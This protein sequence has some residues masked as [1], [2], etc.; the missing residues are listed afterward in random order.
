MK[1]I[2]QYR[3]LAKE[4]QEDAARATDDKLRR[5][6]LDIAD[7]WRQLADERESLVKR[8]SNGN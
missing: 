4:A 2:E 6:L 3:R 8:G 1:K 5:D 7:A